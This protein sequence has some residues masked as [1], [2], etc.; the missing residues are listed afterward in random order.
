[1]KGPERM[2]GG[3][4]IVAGILLLAGAWLLHAGQARPFQVMKETQGGP[5][6]PGGGASNGRGHELGSDGGRLAGLT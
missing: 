6:A 2:F 4:A 1:M 3:S 5:E